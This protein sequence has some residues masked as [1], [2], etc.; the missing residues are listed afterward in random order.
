MSASRARVVNHLPARPGKIKDQKGRP[1]LGRFKTTAARPEK[2]KPLI[3]NYVTKTKRTQW[4]FRHPFS[5]LIIFKLTWNFEDSSSD[6][7]QQLRHSDSSSFKPNSFNSLQEPHSNP[8]NFI[9]R[10][11]KNETNRNL[12]KEKKLENLPCS[13]P[14]SWQS[15]L[16]PGTTCSNVPSKIGNI[17]QLIKLYKIKIT[18]NSSLG[19]S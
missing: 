1:D 17:L 11:A 4:H 8:M 19:D 2:L 3:Y 16:S 12:F 5:E 14:S 6:F 18:S 10:F 7:L 15:G 13:K 9:K